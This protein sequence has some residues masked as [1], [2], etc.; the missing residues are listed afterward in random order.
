M[1]PFLKSLKTELVLKRE[2][3]LVFIYLLLNFIPGLHYRKIHLFPWVTKSLK[4]ISSI[5][6]AKE[7]KSKDQRTHKLTVNLFWK[8]D[9]DF[10]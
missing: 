3:F 4:K 2:I 10:H 9:F 5:S 6:L 8:I 7:V 1:F